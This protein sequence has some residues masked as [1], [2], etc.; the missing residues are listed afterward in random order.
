MELNYKTIIPAILFS[1]LS[2][3]V[4]AQNERIW[5]KTTATAHNSDA[6]VR[7]NSMPEKAE[8]YELDLNQLKSALQGAPVRGQFTG[9]SN[10]V[11]S[12][13]TAYGTMEKFRVMES[14]IMHPGLEEKFPMIK[15]YAAQGIDDPTSTMRFSITQFGV[16]S[17]VLSVKHS[18]N[19]IDPY[20]SDL[21]TYMVYDKQS[22]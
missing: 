10:V 22:R 9:Q 17:M 16:H 7:R 11:I 18:S 13:P 8:Y 5:T 6:K 4:S 12:F 2:I 19:Y 15:T 3:C 20:T 21:K 14:P 1:S